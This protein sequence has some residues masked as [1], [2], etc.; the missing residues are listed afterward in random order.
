MMSDPESQRLFMRQA[1]LRLPVEG[2][3]GCPTVAGPATSS[4]QYAIPK[5]SNT[6]CTLEDT[7]APIYEDSSGKVGIGTSSPT[8]LLDVEGGTTYN[9]SSAPVLSCGN[10]HGVLGLYNDTVW[11]LKSFSG[12]STFGIDVGWN[13]VSLAAINIYLSGTV[14][15]QGN[16]AIDNTTYATSG[17]PLTT[18]HAFELDTWAWN[19]SNGYTIESRSQITATQLDTTNYHA[20]MDFKP[21]SATAFSALYNGNVGIGTTTPQNKLDVSG[22][23]AVGASYAG[24]DAAPSNGLIVQ[25][26]VGIG[27][28]SPQQGLE[29][30][31][32]Q[33]FA[34]TWRPPPG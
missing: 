9:N 15:P 27:T 20:R 22:G 23:V 12:S 13:V 5:W 16:V 26:K 17:N 11:H 28:A 29:L 4:T 1:R 34:S 8:T 2:G 7:L 6:T 14:G 30:G 10:E 3:L 19:G 32:S 24:S 33:V 21:G 18:S 31:A 25:G